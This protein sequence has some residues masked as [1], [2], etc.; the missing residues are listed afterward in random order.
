M[1]APAFLLSLLVVSILSGCASTG[2]SLPTISYEEAA[3]FEKSSYV[4]ASRA[5]APEVIYNQPVNKKED[6]KLPTT[7]N[8]LQRR[9]FKQYWDGGCRNGYA[10]G[11][12]RDISVSDTHHL[13]EITIYNG[14]GE[15]S[16]RTVVAYDFIDNK[17]FYGGLMVILM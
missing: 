1:N 10:Y 16:N 6:C 5:N 15:T 17:V 2:P 13:E 7:T 9:N 4:P 8:Q 14:L 12:G 11:L 3:V